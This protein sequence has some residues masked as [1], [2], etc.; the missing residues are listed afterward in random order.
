[1]YKIYND[2]CGPF[3]KLNIKTFG[4]YSKIDFIEILNKYNA[5]YFFNLNIKPIDYPIYKKELFFL[6]LK[7]I[8]LDLILSPIFNFFDYEDYNLTLNDLR[9]IKDIVLSINP[10]DITFNDIIFFENEEDARSFCKELNN[11]SNYGL[12]YRK[13]NLKWSC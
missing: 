1:M 8:D 5:F 4:R 10:N 6:K 7:N 3:S 13:A 2:F 11:Y 9:L 12:F